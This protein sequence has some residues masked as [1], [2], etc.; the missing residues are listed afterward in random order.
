MSLQH[1]A[2]LGELCRQLGHFLKAERQLRTDE[3]TALREKLERIILTAANMQGNKRTNGA[4]TSACH[5]YP[6]GG[7]QYIVQK[8]T[9]QVITWERERGRERVEKKSMKSST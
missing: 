8:Y 5:L 9:P 2:D 3:V 6:L 1:E 4:L 7:V